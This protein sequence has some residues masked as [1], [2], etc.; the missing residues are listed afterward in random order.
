MAKRD[1]FSFSPQEFSGTVRLFPS[2]GLVLFP[3]VLQP[4]HIFEPRYREM[5]E[6]ALAG[7]SLVT[8]AV[9]APGWENDYE[10]RPPVLPVACL[11]R[12]TV[13]CRLDSGAYNLLLSGLRRVQLVRELPPN[14][15]FREAKAT[16]RDDCY[17]SDHDAT[18]A[19]L[20][21]RL[22]AAFLRLLDQVS[23]VLEQLDQLLGSDISLAALTD[24]VS[25]MLDIDLDAKMALLSEVDVHRRAER[26][27][28]LLANLA[29]DDEPGRHGVIRFP[30]GFS[31][32]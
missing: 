6:E 14:K 3:H 22:R 31:T 23:N 17:P 8:M 20:H 11:G 9:L 4:L 10:G 29:D 25:Y 7:D 2:P 13:H 5:V 27:L 12:V 1:E 28:D 18:G 30:P 21:R 24:I 16:V 15:P 26:L 32:N 19:T